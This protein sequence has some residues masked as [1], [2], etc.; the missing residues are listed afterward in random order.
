MS[1]SR[2]KGGLYKN[3]RHELVRMEKCSA[4]E[5]TGKIGSDEPHWGVGVRNC[6]R[7]DGLGYERIYK[8]VPLSKEE[9]EEITNMGGTILERYEDDD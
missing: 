5:G 6:M 8:I 2:R 4:C 1:E 7:C 9:I 3:Y